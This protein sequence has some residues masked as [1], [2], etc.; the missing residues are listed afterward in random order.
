MRVT[1]DNIGV[2]SIPEGDGQY[3]QASTYYPSLTL[4]E[5]QEY[6]EEINGEL[7]IHLS[8]LYFMV[9]IFR[10]DETWADELSKVPQE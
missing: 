7:A 4:Q 5:R 1:G 3:Q 10:G 6:L 8:I 9:E 2:S